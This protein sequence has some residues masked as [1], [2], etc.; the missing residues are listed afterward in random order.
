MGIYDLMMLAVLAGSILFGLW[1]GLAWQIASVA[2]IFVSYFVALN[3]RGPL[4]SWISA[5]EPWNRFAA[6]L[7]LFLGTS[8]IIWMGYGY[9]KQT[10]ERMRLRGFDSQAGAI[11]GALKGVLLC[12]LVTLFAV[13]LFGSR[14]RSAVVASRSGGYIASAINRFNSTV[15]IEIHAILDQHVQ[16]FNQNLVEQQPDFL[17]K[18]EQKFEEKLETVRGYFELPS[19]SRSTPPAQDQFREFNQPSQNAS[20]Q[21]PAADPNYVPP[22]RRTVGDELF[23]AASQAGRRIINDNLNR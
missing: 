4:S 9:M 12:M 6:M 14:V 16:Q 21:P 7:I 5:S 10:I 15:P 22:E 17:R 1:K 3:F 19:R 13:T 8:L 2:S 11:L 20:F 18:S 23:D